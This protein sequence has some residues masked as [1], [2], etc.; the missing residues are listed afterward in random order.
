MIRNRLAKLL[1]IA[2]ALNF[3]ACGG[4]NEK[5]G[6]DGKAADAAPSVNAPSPTPAANVATTADTTPNSKAPS[7]V[8]TARPGASPTSESRGTGNAP[9]AKMP[10]PQI[11]SGGNDL[12]LFT[13]AR[14]AVNADPELKAANLIVEVKEGV[15][16]LSGTVA[17]AALKS[18]AEE[19]ARGAGPKDV[20]NQLRVSAGK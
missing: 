10:T 18:K 3:S 11:G 19:L 15:V 6:G 7:G 9:P 2:A 4:V 8:A 13:K 12:F 16:T 20:R 14:A 17:S 5:T 1:I